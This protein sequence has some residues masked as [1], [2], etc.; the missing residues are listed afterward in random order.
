M[1]QDHWGYLTNWWQKASRL[2]LCRRRVPEYFANAK[3]KKINHYFRCENKVYQVQILANDK[4]LGLTYNFTGGH[5]KRV[6]TVT[7]DNMAERPSPL[8]KIYR[9]FSPCLFL[10]AAQLLWVD[11]QC[12]GTHWRKS[13]LQWFGISSQFRLKVS[14]GDEGVSHVCFPRDQGVD[15]PWRGYRCVQMNVGPA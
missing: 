12:Y 2:L 4:H 8:R 15:Q 7:L 6:A 3:N 1:Y 14:C 5:H 9:K 11:C 10:T 13:E